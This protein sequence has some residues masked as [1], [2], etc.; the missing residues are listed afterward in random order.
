MK[1]STLEAFHRDMNQAIGVYLGAKVSAETFSKVRSSLLQVVNRYLSQGLIDYCPMIIDVNNIEEI[2]FI[3]NK[4]KELEEQLSD[5]RNW[6]RENEIRNQQTLLYW[7]LSSLTQMNSDGINISFKD[8]VTFKT[9][10]WVAD[11]E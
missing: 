7:R 5:I 6:D 1:K 9:I 11:E 10:E 8:P 3:R 2:E 4:H